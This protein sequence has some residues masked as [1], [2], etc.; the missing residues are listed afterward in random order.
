MLLG[1]AL[2]ALGMVRRYLTQLTNDFPAK[3][4]GP[5]DAGSKVAVPLDGHFV[6]CT[7]S[8]V[9]L[10]ALFPQE[11]PSPATARETRATL[12]SVLLQAITG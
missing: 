11:L 1:A 4:P 12:G 8:P 2:G 9:R 7:G 3:R 6:F 10:G 5:R